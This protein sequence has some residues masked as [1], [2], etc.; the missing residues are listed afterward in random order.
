MCGSEQPGVAIVDYGV[1]NLFSISNA[2]RMVGLDARI[3]SLSDDILHADAVILPGV[4]AFG[5]AMESLK[6]MNLID[7]LK[8]A[9]FSSKPFLGICL[10]MQLLMSKSYEFGLHSGLGII[11]GVVL[12]FENHKDKSRGTIKVPHVGWNRIYQDSKALVKNLWSGTILGG[13]GNGE[14]MYFVHS[15]YVKPDDVSQ[16]LSISNYGDNEFCSSIKCKNVYGCQ[17][18]PERS[19]PEG[20]KVYQNLLKIITENKQGIKNKL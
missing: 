17:F 11:Q 3:T 7:T 20:L 10:G 19:G 18:H 4:G 5:D 8:E 15:Y 9:A 12:R 14:F 13:I 2:C 16:S 1:G 6:R